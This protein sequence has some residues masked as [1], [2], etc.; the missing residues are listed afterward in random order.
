VS[1][2]ARL[3]VQWMKEL[4]KQIYEIESNH[5]QICMRLSD[6]QRRPIGPEINNLFESANVLR[7]V[8]DSMKLRLDKLE[9]G[10][11]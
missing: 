1:N 9:Q 3:I 8:R 10:E 11:Q 2:E 5:T 6:K 7:N 4:E